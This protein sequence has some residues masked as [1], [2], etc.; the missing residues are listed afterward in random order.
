MERR[1]QKEQD[2]HLRKKKEEKCENH[3]LKHLQK[4]SKWVLVAIVFD[5]IHYNI[6]PIFPEELQLYVYDS[7]QSIAFLFYIYAIYKIIPKQL[8]L[9]HFILSAWVWFS[10]G[11]VFNVVYNYN[12]VNE[13]RFENYCLLLNILMMCYKFREHLYLQYAILLFNLKIERNEGLF[14]VI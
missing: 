13:I 14:K 5:L 3:V 7:T 8:M 12:A 11:D 10:L 6:Y 1:K 4:Q 9:M 2:D